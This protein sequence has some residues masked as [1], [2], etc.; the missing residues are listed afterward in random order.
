MNEKEVAAVG[1]HRYGLPTPRN[2]GFGHSPALLIVDFIKGFT[3]LDS[4]L[5]GNWDEEIQFTAEILKSARQQGIPVV[6]TTVEYTPRELSTNL[7]YKKTPN[8]GILA[9]GSV[10]TEVDQ[11]LEVDP[12]DLLISKKFGSAFFG[13]SL[14]SQLQVLGVDTLLIAGCVT[15]GCVRASGVDAVQSGFRPSIIKNASGDRSAVVHEANLIDF[16]QLYGDV[17]SMSDALNYIAGLRSFRGCDLGEHDEHNEH[18]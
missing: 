6:F 17:V 8:I 4:P 15:S 14:A 16:E 3:H 1:L 11:R 7:L 9:K 2:L 5:A 12:H 10:W 13:T 18:V